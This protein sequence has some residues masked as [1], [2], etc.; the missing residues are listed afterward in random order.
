MTATAHHPDDEAVFCHIIPLGDWR[1]H[2]ASCACWCRP[3]PH[4]DD[5]EVML[6]NAMDQRDKLVRGEIRIQ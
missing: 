4:D 5:P 3:K 6:H 1:D 2:E